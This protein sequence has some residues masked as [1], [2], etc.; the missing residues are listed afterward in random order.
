L[1]AA[2]EVFVL[3]PDGLKWELARVLPNAH[4]FTSTGQ[5]LEG[6][7]H[8][9]QPEDSVVIMSNG[10]FDGLHQRFLSALQHSQEA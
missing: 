9:A 10:S 5:L 4:V 3:Q 2:D 8:E 1:R 6:L 7:L